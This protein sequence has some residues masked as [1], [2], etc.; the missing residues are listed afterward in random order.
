MLLNVSHIF[1][2]FGEDSIIKDA[3]FTVDEGSKVAI[4]GNNGTGKS[5]LL[6]I[7]VGDLPADSGEVTLKKDATMGYLAQYQE[8]CS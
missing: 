5:T 6:K 8:D 7:I 3:T 2:S 4:V 1:K